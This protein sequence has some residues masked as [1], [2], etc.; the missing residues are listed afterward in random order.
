MM[1]NTTPD[2]TEGAPAATDA[3]VRQFRREGWTRFDGLLDQ[4]ALTRVR[5]ALGRAEE[6]SRAQSSGRAVSYRD[7]PRFR[8][9]LANLR[10]GPEASRELRIG[11]DPRI[12]GVARSLLGVEH[13][14]LWQEGG[15]I[16]PPQ[17]EGT[18]PTQWHQDLPLQPFDRRD[19][20]TIWIAV[21][22][23]PLEAGP[24]AFIPGSHRLGPLGRVNPA[25]EGDDFRARLPEE[26]VEFLGQVV[27]QPYRAGD[28][29]AHGGL[30]LHSAGENRSE[31][32]RRAWA[33]TY[34]SSTTRYTGAPSPSLAGLELEAGEPFDR[35]LFPIIV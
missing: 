12:A 19:T 24:L 8:A 33:V 9:M 21:E 27:R 5:A 22:D 29:T 26:D 18:R 15:L 25:I 11:W 16:K 14:Q 35:E 4:P 28:A 23:I 13:V 32:P 3:H 30:V 17:A 31:R 7:D 1:L 6:A 34:M 10:V 2:G 20:V